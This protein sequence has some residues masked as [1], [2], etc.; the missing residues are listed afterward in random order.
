MKNNGYCGIGIECGKTEFNYW[1]LFRT[2]QI[3]DC[4]FLF[5]IG[6][7]YERHSADTMSSYKHIPVYSYIDI[8]DF[9]SHRPFSCRLVG[10][11]MDKNAIDIKNYSH[12][13]N[14]IYLLGSEDNGLSQKAI[15]LCQEIIF[16]PGEKSLNVSVAGSIVL[17]DRYIKKGE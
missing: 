4:D 12:P 9:N 8:D 17:Y 16:L 1:T 7:R 13:Q 2:A 10:I 11:E 6:E 15:K 3:F 5:V 14:A